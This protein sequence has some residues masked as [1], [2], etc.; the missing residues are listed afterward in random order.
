MEAP[1][2]KAAQEAAELAQQAAR[3]R[4]EAEAARREAAETRKLIDLVRKD[5]VKFLKEVAKI[6]D[7]K[8]LDRISRDVYMYT[9]GDK[10]P[11]AYSEVQ[12]RRENETEVDMLRRKVYEV[13]NKIE[14]RHMEEAS[15]AAMNDYVAKSKSTMSAVQAKEA[16]WV[17]RHFKANP[18]AATQELVN[19][20]VYVH[21]QTGETMQPADL[22]S[23]LESEMT[24]KFGKYDF[25]E[26]RPTTPTLN[27]SLST[28]AKRSSPGMDDSKESSLERIIAGIEA[29]EHLRE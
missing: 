28:P 26:A 17:A 2:A 18:D 5:P 1:A 13:E 11:Q 19:L 15:R 23:V 7:P 4:D 12:R 20:A 21:Q 27:N 6:E 22:I 9:L 16:P 8:E 14:S 10:A 3:A 24:K 25:G 29:G